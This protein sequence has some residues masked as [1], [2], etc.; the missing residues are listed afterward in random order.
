MNNTINQIING[1]DK[2]NNRPM[3]THV[4][5]MV[6]LLEELR[7]EFNHKFDNVLK[8]VFANTTDTIDVL[9][10]P[11]LKVLEKLILVI[12]RNKETITTNTLIELTG[13]AKQA[14]NRSL[15]NLRNEG[16]VKKI[17]A[18]TYSIVNPNI[19]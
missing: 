11:N 9:V 6:D 10:L 16:Y 17:K 2:N 13:C 14:V 3:K 1:D 7:F 18:S 5:Q 12:L 4:K 8:P 19:F 15:N